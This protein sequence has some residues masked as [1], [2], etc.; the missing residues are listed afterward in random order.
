MVGGSILPLFGRL[1]ELVWVWPVVELP[2]DIQA[3]QYSTFGY[4]SNFSWFGGVHSLCFRIILPVLA[5]LAPIWWVEFGFPTKLG[6]CSTA[7][8]LFFSGINLPSKIAC[9]SD[10]I[11]LGLPGSQWAFPIVH[12]KPP[13]APSRCRSLPPSYWRSLISQFLLQFSQTSELLPELFLDIDSNSSSIIWSFFCLAS[14]SLV[15]LSPL[16]SKL[17]PCFLLLSRYISDFHIMLRLLLVSTLWVPRFVFAFLS[18]MYFFREHS[19]A[20]LLLFFFS[21]RLCPR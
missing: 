1:L 13:P 16:I 15:R 19:S 17:R 18:G 5:N 10:Q 14:R 6:F 9:Q 8:L 7:Y 4:R 3:S 20:K 2:A 12:L 11:F 21:P